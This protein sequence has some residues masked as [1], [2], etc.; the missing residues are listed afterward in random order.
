MSNIKLIVTDLDETLLTTDK[1]ITERTIETIEKCRAKGIKFV[2]ATARAIRILEKLALTKGLSYDALITLNG[3]RAYLDGE[4]IYHKG[5]TPA[6]RDA[7][8]PPIRKTFPGFGLS[9]DIHGISYAD[10][11]LSQWEDDFVW[12]TD[13]TDLPDEIADRMIMHLQDQANLS[14]LEAVLP[15]YLYAHLVEG[16]PLT[17]ILHK[18]VSKAHA[19]KH[20]CDMWGI[21]PEEI[22]VFG[23][24]HNDIQMF[25]FAGHAVAV[26]NA[27]DELKAIATDT[28]LDNNHDGVAVWLEKHVLGAE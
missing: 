23:D 9:V 12:T 20:V 15:D 28:T 25:E 16:T 26:A 17:R 7:A 1:K 8:I 22:V 27:V 2:P 13:F 24:D 6:E 10:H 5:M 14:K 18:G 19:I 4:L 3:S 21:K 11:D